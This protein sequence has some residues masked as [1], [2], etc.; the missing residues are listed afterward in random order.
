MGRSPRRLKTIRKPDLV[1]G[2]QKAEVVSGVDGVQ[3]Q[4]N[5][6]EIKCIVEVFRTLLR[7]DNQRQP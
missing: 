4:L 7:W 2:T 6:D 3:R 1:E 5:V